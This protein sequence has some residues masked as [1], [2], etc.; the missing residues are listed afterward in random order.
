MSF[1]PLRHQ[2]LESGQIVLRHMAAPVRELDRHAHARHT[3]RRAGNGGPRARRR[4]SQHLHALAEAVERLEQPLQS[5][6]TDHLRRVRLNDVIDRRRLGIGTVA[7]PAYRPV[8]RGPA[9]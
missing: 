5:L 4:R 1:R 2:A 9:W 6:A 8:P 3:R 7:R